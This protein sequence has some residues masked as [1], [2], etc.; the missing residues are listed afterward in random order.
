MSIALY[1]N[2][3]LIFA[4]KATPPREEGKVAH[5]QYERFDRDG[6]AACGRVALITGGSRGI[7]AA[8]V[9]RFCDAGVRVAFTFRLSAAEAAEL[10]EKTG[11]TP[12]QMDVTDRAVAEA[13]R[14]IIRA[15]GHIDILVNNAGVALNR[16]LMDTDD[17]EYRRVMDTNV[18]GTFN[19]TRA[20]LPH[21]IE[22]RGGAIINLS[23][24]WGQ[25]GGAGEAVYSASKAAVIGLTRATAKEVASAGIRVNCIAPGIIDTAMNADLSEGD[26]AEI[27]NEIP[28]GRVGSAA[29]VAEAA[30]FLA[31]DAAR[32][33]TGQV[34]P[35]NGGWRM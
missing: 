11:A 9:R 24:I 23:S 10:A 7:G 2:I 29:D 8:M 33:I 22:R 31:S 21:M 35:V 28:L 26:V 1:K 27:C 12:V 17:A 25:E 19:V 5:N 4:A 20:V 18:Y 14:E 32:Y 3:E 15:Q 34:L 16:L 13:V 6:T 30:L